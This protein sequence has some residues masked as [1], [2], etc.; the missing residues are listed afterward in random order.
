MSLNCEMAGEGGGGEPGKC[1]SLNF[2]QIILF[3]KK[4]LL[5]IENRQ[6]C[7]WFKYFVIIF[8]EK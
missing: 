6:T 4:N 2:Q 3:I 5:V 1:Q 8:L 7:Y